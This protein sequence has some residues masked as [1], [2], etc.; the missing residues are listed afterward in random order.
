MSG[1]ALHRYC[2]TSLNY[3]DG[4]SDRLLMLC[5]F[6]LCCG[7]IKLRKLMASVVTIFIF[8]GIAS[9]ILA[10]QLMNDEFWEIFDEE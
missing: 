2:E 6:G 4:E 7:S 9:G 5:F 8:T 10:A 1:A 3:G